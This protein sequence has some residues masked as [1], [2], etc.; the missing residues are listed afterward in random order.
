[1]CKSEHSTSRL[2]PS[3]EKEYGNRD[4]LDYY[5]KKRKRLRLSESTLRTIYHYFFNYNYS[6]RSPHRWPT[7]DRRVLDDTCTSYSRP[8]VT[9]DA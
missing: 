2:N 7:S 8:Q 1:M 4:Y 3:F 9:L 6:E 5:L